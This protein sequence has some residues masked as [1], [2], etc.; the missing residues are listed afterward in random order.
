V[1]LDISAAM[2]TV[3]QSLPAPVGAPIEWLE[4]DASMLPFPDSSFD[5][6]LC[7]QGLQ[8]FARRLDAAAEVRR[9]LAPGGRAVLVVWQALARNP[10]QEALNTAALCRTGIAPLATA[11]CLHDKDEVGALFAAARLPDVTI[12]GRELNIVFPSRAEF[13]QRMV[14]SV[15]HIA[16]E[17]AGLGA[18][19]RAELACGITLDVRETL[20]SHAWGGGIACPMAANFIQVNKN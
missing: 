2:L 7:Q 1:A 15:A 4:G 9:V 17:L 12:T 19:Q 18:T 16:P 20:Q 5:A 3:G 13:V 10:V 14:E 8:Y 11:Y 6:V